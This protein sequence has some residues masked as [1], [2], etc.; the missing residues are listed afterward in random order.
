MWFLKLTVPFAP[1]ALCR[2]EAQGEIAAIATDPQYAE[3]GLGRRIVNYLIEKARKNR[4]SRVFI[5]TTKTQDWFEA[6]G[7]QEAPIDSLPAQKRKIYDHKRN[8]KV[9]ALVL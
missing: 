3:L 4:M 9:F 5:L 7:F 1:A 8:S 2:G 6:L